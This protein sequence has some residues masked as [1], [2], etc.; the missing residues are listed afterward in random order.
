MSQWAHL[1]RGCLVGSRPARIGSPSVALLAAVADLRSLMAGLFRLWNTTINMH[2]ISSFPCQSVT[3]SVT[4]FL[5][6]VFVVLFLPLLVVVFAVLVII[7]DIVV[8]C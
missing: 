4:F 1:E 3:F 6:N 5:V 8:N 7:Q 2:Q